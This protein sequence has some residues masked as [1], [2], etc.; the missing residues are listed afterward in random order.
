MGII[1]DFDHKEQKQKIGPQ[2][3]ATRLFRRLQAVV[4]IGGTLSGLIFSVLT[5]VKHQPVAATARPTTTTA[6]AM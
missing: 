4:N 2:G 1:N 6:M 3:T 5:G